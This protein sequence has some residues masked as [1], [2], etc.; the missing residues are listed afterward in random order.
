M[1]RKTSHRSTSSPLSGLD[2]QFENIGPACRRTALT[3]D[4]IRATGG[5]VEIAPIVGIVDPPSIGPLR[6][7]SCSRSTPTS[8]RRSSAT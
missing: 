6:S 3:R 8:R 7:V 1:V 2:L 4:C 5:A